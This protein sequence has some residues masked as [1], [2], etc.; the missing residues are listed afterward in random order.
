MCVIMAKAYARFN[1]FSET[2]KLRERKGAGLSSR[3]TARIEASSEA[4]HG[5]R[6][7][8][9]SSNAQRGGC[10]LNF[11]ASHSAAAAR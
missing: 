10:R 9:D 11:H 6:K 8:R 7:E 4:N 5:R 1:A 2:N 3:S